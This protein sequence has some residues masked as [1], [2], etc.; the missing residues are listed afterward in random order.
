MASAGPAIAIRGSSTVNVA[1]CPRG[2]RGRDRPAVRLHDGA[3]DRKPQAGPAGGAP[4]RGIRPGEPVEERRQKGWV[5]PLPGVRHLQGDGVTVRFDA[6]ADRPPGGRVPHRVRDEVQEHLLDGVAVALDHRARRGVHAPG[7]VAEDRGPR[8]DSAGELADVDG[9]ASRPAVGAGARQPQ[10][11]LDQPSHP[12]ELGDRDAN[13]RVE[14]GRVVAR[15]ERRLEVSARDR[16]RRSQLVRRVV[17][18]APLGGERALETVEHGVDR[19]RDVGDLVVRPYRPHPHGE[20]AGRDARRALGDA[21]QRCEGPS[22]H[23][24]CRP[25]GGNK[26]D[27]ADDEHRVEQRADAGLGLGRGRRPR[28][29]L[30]HGGPPTRRIPPRRPR[31]LAPPT[32]ISVRAHNRCARWLFARGNPLGG[33]MASSCPDPP[34]AWR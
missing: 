28:T 15:N 29:V 12:V 1:P 31:P 21:R 14:L 16:E 13:G 32:G 4:T 17:D 20:V 3:A 19:D 6:H 23:E 5:D 9:L 34:R 11:A 25:G 7:P 22:R 26:A 30:R 33:M 8:H 18:E 2:A 24:P 27:E 10:K